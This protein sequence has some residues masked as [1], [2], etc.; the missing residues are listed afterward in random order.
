MEEKSLVGGKTNNVHQTLFITIMMWV[1]YFHF[2]PLK[3]SFRIRLHYKG[4]PNTQSCFAPLVRQ[5]LD[6]NESLLLSLFLLDLQ[7]QLKTNVL[8]HEFQP[9]C[10]A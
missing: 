6:A 2:H 8:S 5:L 9:G 7:V 10:S 3:N 1:S 4:Q